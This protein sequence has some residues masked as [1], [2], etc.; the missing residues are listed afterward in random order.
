MRSVKSILVAT[1]ASA[2]SD[3]VMRTAAAIAA[4]TGAELH[5][6]H[7]FDFPVVSP[8]EEKRAG[9]TFADMVEAARKRLDEQVARTVRQGVKLSSCEVVVYVAHKAILEQAAAVKADIIVM[10]PHRGKPGTIPFLGST[11]DRVV[12]TADVPVLIARAPLSLPLRR[13]LVP[14][15]LSEP[16]LGALHLALEWQQSLPAAD[17]DVQELVVLHVIPQVLDSGDLE[18]VVGQDLHGEVR[19]TIADVAGAEHVH[20]REEVRWGDSP[21]AVINQVI[22]EEQVDLV[23]LGTH[24][25]GLIKRA[26]V[27]SVAS[28]VARA[29]ACPV[30]LIPPS[31]KD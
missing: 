23:V 8:T 1:D 7:S 12:R 21:A 3:D 10:G 28:A 17:Q 19:D 2:D 20:L 31:L 30:L 24:G 13:V 11:A 18:G 25:Y 29:A 4:L 27:G 5:A 15:D 9:V 14:L 22:V 6:I 26:L 16:A